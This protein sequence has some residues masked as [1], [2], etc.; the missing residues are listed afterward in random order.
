MAEVVIFDMDGILVDSEYYKIKAWQKAFRTIGIELE[1]DDMI[2]EWVVKGTSFDETVR[3]FNREDVVEDDLRPIVTEQYLKSIDAEVCLLPGAREA[4][5]RL[6]SEFLLGLA[7]SSHKMYV[8]KLIE[9][10]GIADKFRAIACGSEVE[11]L[12]PYPDVML[13]AAERMGVDPKVCVA[14]DDAPK[15]VIAAKR[16]GMKAIA[17]PT[18]HTQYG[19][20]DEAGIVLPS[21]DEVTVELIQMM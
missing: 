13:L 9:K 14:I 10:F 17:V 19:D 7:S 2:R 1:E 6:H 11:R 20:F 21:L 8:E 18:K 12:K 5:D 15:G 16:A 3:M 4:L